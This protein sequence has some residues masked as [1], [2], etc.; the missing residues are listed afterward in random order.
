MLETRTRSV[1][2]TARKHLD[3]RCPRLVLVWHP[4]L[5]RVG[6]SLWLPELEDARTV[7]LSR[8]APAF[9]PSTG[10]QPPRP[11]AE[12]TVSRRPVL[13]EPRGEGLRLVAQ[14]ARVE[15]DGV[16]LD[17]AVDLDR[18]RL[19]RGVLLCLGSRVLLHLRRQV[20]VSPVPP[21]FALVGVGPALLALRRDIAALGPL[22]APILLQG[23]SGTGKELV[24]AAL[25]ENAGAE[26]GPMQVLNMAALAPTLA[27]S[28]LFGAVRG[29]FSGANRDRPGYFDRA[30]GGTL[31]LDEIGETP[32]EVQGMLLRALESGE[33]QPVG[34][35]QVHRV[36][37][38][39]LA[40]TDADLEAAIEAGSF[41]RALYQRLSALRIR[42]PPLRE[43]I[44]DLGPLLLHFLRQELSRHGREHVLEYGD[45]FARPF[46]SARLVAQLAR[47]SWPGNVRE[48]RNRIRQLVAENGDAP[49]LAE[50]GSGS[51]GAATDPSSADP[52][53]AGPGA[54]SRARPR[55]PTERQAYRDPSSVD[56][57]ELARALERH[58]WNIRAA[59]RELGLSRAV[60]Y[61][62][63][64]HHPHLRHVGDLADAEVEEALERS[65]GD[66][67]TA[68]RGLRVSKQGLKRRWR[69]LQSNQEQ[70]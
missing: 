23:E 7:A 5:G 29:A 32:R 11:L 45:P 21:D 49:Y 24:A 4:D 59:A 12:P 41:S 52:S 46:V 42:L 22:D 48:L 55:P 62:R 34:A 35:G 1:P 30:D 9:P 38:R 37:V 31:F 43:R 70:P 64:T 15:V 14:S 3:V 40:A 27:A 10:T 57:D 44:E 33:V 39:V 6:E 19:E 16:G 50:S 65:G 54:R 60:T 36:D 26:R 58:Q 63:I 8:T 66:M 67:A 69:R 18:D 53:S 13:L 28:E 17:G 25:A 56:D 61:D 2:T 47:E 20:P 51:F 68:A